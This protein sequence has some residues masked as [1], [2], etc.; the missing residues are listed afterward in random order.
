MMKQQRDHRRKHIVQ[1]ART[2]N[3]RRSLQQLILGAIGKS[4]QIPLQK[5]SHSQDSLV[6]LLWPSGIVLVLLP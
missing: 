2:L 6:V 1:A 5:E 4:N 3:Y